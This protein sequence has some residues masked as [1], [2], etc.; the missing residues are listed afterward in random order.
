MMFK[1]YIKIALRG[2]VKHRAYSLINI[3]GLATGMAVTLL[4]G[5]WVYYEATYDRFLPDHEQVY[6]IKRH[7]THEGITHTIDAISLPLVEV[8][9]HDIPGIEYVALSDWGGAHSLMVG[10][11]KISSNGHFV[12]ED[13]LQF[14]KYPLVRGEAQAVLST[15][16]SI[17]LTA[18]TAKALFGEKD[19]MNQTVRLDNSE[20]L[21][22]TGVLENIPMHS[23]LQFNYLLP[24]SL[25]ENMSPYVR[26]AQSEW[27]IN[28]FMLYVGLA[29]GV[30]SEQ[31]N[32]LIENILAEKSPE[33]R[34]FDP[35]L[36]LHPLTDWHL[37][38][39]FEN[40]KAVGGYIEYVR[41]FG[42]IGLLVLIIACINFMNLSTARSEKRAKEVGV[43]KAIG[44]KRKHLIVQFL[45]ESLLLTI[46]SFGLALLLVH[47][48]LDPFNRLVGSEIRMPFGQ[49]IF[50][51]IMFGY[52]GVTSLLAGS[53]PAFYLS[54][55]NAVKVLK[56]GVQ[57]QQS[58]VW[59]RKAL[60]LLQFSCS[61]ALIISTI[62]IYEQIQH[63]RNRPVGYH[64]D[65]L[66]MS[67][68]SEDL[69]RNYEAL[70]SDLLNSGLVEQV[71]RASSSAT[72]INFFTLI[73]DW[74]GKTPDGPHLEIGA[75]RIT[76]TYFE[77]MGMEIVKGR[78]FKANL[79]ADSSSVILNESA[80]RRL[81]LED[82]IGQVINW[83]RDQNVT[84]VGVAKD[85]ILLS[86]YTP[87][88]PTLFAPS[89]NHE[90]SILYRLSP[91]TH[92]QEAIPQ[93]AG[94]FNRYNPAFPFEYEF[95]DTAYAQKF[96]LEVL[97][98]KLAGL[99]AGLAIFVSCLGLFGLAAFMAEQ[100]R[101]EIGIR[102]VLGASLAQIWMLLSREFLLLVLV[103]CL[104]AAPIALYFLQDW[105][106]QY[107]YRI[108]IS[109]L[110][111]I[112]SAVL[113]LTITIITISFQ[114]I[115]A[116]T[117]RPVDSLRTE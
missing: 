86:P 52:I 54:S 39:Q 46:I 45:S 2:L 33:L 101:K 15:P 20:E 75:V 60:V 85:A 110:T 7:Y 40:G 10:D 115:R 62:I 6:Q 71:A 103:S 104:L 53:R 4:I 18:Q 89:F 41:L 17:V 3:L 58:A 32:P 90:S 23:S 113:A 43:R 91:G 8:L 37:F 117:A 57:R 12:G 76:D 68:M 64:Q 108:S 55:F 14:I 42:F 16:N 80:I 44:S 98:G 47:L 114:A 88:H 111:F 79:E 99:F 107:D 67:E 93:L 87:V 63:V 116:G 95:A 19:P 36:S 84:I 25:L 22:V 61:I 11:T 92:P 50:W 112:L 24:F 34:P 9:K 13:F 27:L 48:A 38:N 72:G 56:G 105:L 69:N 51:L 29:P 102:K 83:N 49:P 81:K 28:S 30:D 94:I 97:V 35:K 70:K 66:M 109:P 59:G 96:Q 65:G 82:P 1:N 26:Q 78:G 106:M 5:L 77:T 73:A 31:V 21:I 100:R 74:P